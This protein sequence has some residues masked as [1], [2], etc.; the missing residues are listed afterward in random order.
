MV[1][2]LAHGDQVALRHAGDVP[3]HGVVQPHPVLVHELQDDRGDEGLGDAA[4]A[5]VPVGPR[6]AGGVRAW[7][8]GVLDGERGTRRPPLLDPLVQSGKAQAR[9]GTAPTAAVPIIMPA[10]P[11]K[12]ATA[13]HGERRMIDCGKPTP[14]PAS[15]PCPSAGA[16]AG[17]GRE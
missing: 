5:E 6:L 9:A 15:R 12:A 13:D 16:L 10:T 8:G 2:H 7:A 17:S 4:D 1:E 3:A 11:G 14:R